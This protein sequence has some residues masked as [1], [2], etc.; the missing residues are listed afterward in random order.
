MALVIIVECILD[1]FRKPKKGS[2]AV[3]SKSASSVD[4][5]M[6]RAGQCNRHHILNST[7]EIHATTALV[8][9]DAR[10]TPVSD[11]SGLMT[12]QIHS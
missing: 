6:H 7:A 1:A 11:L 5:D 12:M 2:R 8:A 9:R 10:D 3:D 4:C